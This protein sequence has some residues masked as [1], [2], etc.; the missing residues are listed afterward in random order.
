MADVLS[1]ETFLLIGFMA[2]WAVSGEHFLRYDDFPRQHK[3]PTSINRYPSTTEQRLLV[4]GWNAIPLHFL[5]P[6]DC[7]EGRE[8]E[9]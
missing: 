2:Y 6:K 9:N 4:C 7:L 5:E 8:K 1:K 3:W